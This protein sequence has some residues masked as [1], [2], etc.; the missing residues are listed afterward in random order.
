MNSGLFLNFIGTVIETKSGR[1]YPVDKQDWKIRDGIV[2]LIR[3]A[4]LKNYK[5]LIV[6]N[7]FHIEE[8]LSLEKSINDILFKACVVLESR[9]RHKN[10]KIQYSY[11]DSDKTSFRTKPNPGMAYELAMDYELSLKDSFLVSNDILDR[12]FAFNSGIRYFCNFDDIDNV[13]L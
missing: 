4:S 8:E 5:V 1:K 2:N 12:E 13:K 6:T 10:F 9:I 11:S 3:K 7:Q